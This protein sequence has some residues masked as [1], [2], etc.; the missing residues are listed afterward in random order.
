MQ[1]SDAKNAGFTEGVSTWLTVN[2][3]YTY[4][5]AEQAQNEADSIYH[6][7][8]SL[9]EFRKENPVLVYGDYVDLLPED[10]HLWVFSRCL[11]GVE[12]LVVANFSSES[13]SLSDIEILKKKQALMGNYTEGGISDMLRPYEVRIFH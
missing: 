3:N 8:R 10:A 5:N 12:L 4:I 2:P 7:Y 13:V 9:I 1:W 6:Y 11:E